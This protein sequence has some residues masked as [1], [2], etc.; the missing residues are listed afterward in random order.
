MAK[1]LVAAGVALLLV[2]D[3]YFLD[4]IALSLVEKAN[5]LN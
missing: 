1:M 4:K 2:V 5:R 3:V